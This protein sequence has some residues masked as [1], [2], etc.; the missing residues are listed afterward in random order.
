MN[1]RLRSRALVHMCSTC[2]HDTVHARGFNNIHTC[3][4]T[5]MYIHTYICIH[6]YVKNQRKDQGICFSLT[7]IAHSVTR[8]V[9]YDIYAVRHF[10][11]RFIMRERET[12]RNKSDE[13]THLYVWVTMWLQLMRYT[14]IFFCMHDITPRCCSSRALSRNPRR[15]QHLRPRRR[16]RYH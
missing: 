6:I 3:E 1:G 9:S 8:D 5:H 16:C 14:S 2:F 11:T 15:P 7:S 4:C 13:T 10:N 12:K